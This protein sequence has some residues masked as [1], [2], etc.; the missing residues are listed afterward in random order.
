MGISDF[1]FGERVPVLVGTGAHR[2]RRRMTPE[3]IEALRARGRPVVRL[4]RVPVHLLDGLKGPQETAWTVG[5][6]VAEEVVARM[7]DPGTGALYAVVLYEGAE[8]REVKVTDPDRWA[9]LSEEYRQ[10]DEGGGSL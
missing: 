2:R 10:W 4:D 5:E 8:V 1:L 9:A 7:A 3:R 6:D